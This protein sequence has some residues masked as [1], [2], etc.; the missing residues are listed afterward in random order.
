MR[1]AFQAAGG[2]LAVAVIFHTGALV[3]SGAA[4]IVML[5]VAGALALSLV[6][7]AAKAEW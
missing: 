1:T 6:T 3:A 5:A 7:L 2:L 4:S